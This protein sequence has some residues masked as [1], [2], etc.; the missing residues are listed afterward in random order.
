MKPLV[1][2]LD[3]QDM[4]RAPAALL[5]AAKRA[6]QLAQETGTELVVVRNGKLVR[7]VCR[8][9]KRVLSQEKGKQPANKLAVTVSNISQKTIITRKACGVWI[10]GL[11]S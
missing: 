1:S 9:P 3:D 8:K 4:Q 7:E 2:N 6:R 5:R 10:P 11:F